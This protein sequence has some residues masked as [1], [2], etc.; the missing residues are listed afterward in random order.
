M[1]DAHLTRARDDDDV[2]AAETLWE[3]DISRSD[4]VHVLTKHGRYQRG[5]ESRESFTSERLRRNRNA[6]I[7][8]FES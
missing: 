2:P 8:P 4:R 6:L 7:V 1:A 5:G 3:W